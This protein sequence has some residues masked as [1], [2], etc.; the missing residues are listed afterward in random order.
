MGLSRASVLQ[1]TPGGYIT[2][3]RAMKAIVD[4]LTWE[5][6]HVVS[7]RVDTL[8]E[9]VRSFF[10]R[11]AVVKTQSWCAEWIEGVLRQWV[12]QILRFDQ[13]GVVQY[14][15]R[16][17][18]HFKSRRILSLSTRRGNTEIEGCGPLIAMQTC[19]GRRSVELK[20][21]HINRDHC[22]TQISKVAQRT[23]VSRSGPLKMR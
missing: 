16:V 5:R 23:R 19:L 4:T 14:F 1:V 18:A 2:E 15:T 20:N 6:D 7:A 12:S 10:V 17:L 9:H 13:V 11:L 8:T 3:A 21:I 22:E